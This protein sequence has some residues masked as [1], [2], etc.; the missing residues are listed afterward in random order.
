MPVTRMSPR[1]SLHSSRHHRRQ[2]EL[3]EPRHLGR[4]DAQDHAGL[5]ALLEDVDAVAHAVG[6]AVREVGVVV[7]V[8]DLALL[9]AHQVHGEGADDLRRQ[10][11]RIAQRAQVALDAEDRR[12]PGLEVHVRGPELPGRPKHV[13]ENLVHGH[14]VPQHATISPAYVCAIAAP[15]ARRSCPSRPPSAP[16]A[17]AASR[18]GRVPKDATPAAGEPSLPGDEEATR[19]MS[20]TPSLLRAAALSV[21]KGGKKDEP[22]QAKAAAQELSRR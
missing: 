15:T 3:V 18:A 19:Q 20:P 17:A 13:V 10:R 2:V 5:P 22:R 4:D 11:R 9:L 16:T 14:I 7:L 6:R 1:S 12:Q 8:E 21:K